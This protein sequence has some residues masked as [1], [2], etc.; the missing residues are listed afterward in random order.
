MSSK[1]RR[2][3]TTERLSGPTTR[4]QTKKEEKAQ[5]EAVEEQQEQSILDL[6]PE[7]TFQTP[8]SVPRSV[9][10]E[11]FASTT[12]Q[13]K[14]EVAAHSPLD[15][16]TTPSLTSQNNDDDADA[17]MATNT[18]IASAEVQ[19]AK[20][21]ADTSS[22]KTVMITD[23]DKQAAI[24]VD[25]WHIA[26]DA[27]LRAWVEQ[28]PAGVLSMINTLRAQ[29]DQGR[30]LAEDI[31]DTT[32]DDGKDREIRRLRV[33]V[34]NADG[35]SENLRNQ[36][37]GLETH[38]EELAEQ[39]RELRERQREASTSTFGDGTKKLSPKLKD[40]PVFT[41]EE[42]GDV[43]Y[44][45]WEMSIEDRL[46]V[47]ADHYPTDELKVIFMCNSVGGEA[48]EHI[49]PR[50]DRESSNPFKKP[51]EVYEH[52][53]SIYGEV[54]R[55]GTARREYRKTYQGVNGRFGAFKSK[56]LRLGGVLNYDESIIRDDM[57]D[58]M[59]PRLRD[60][61]RNNPHIRHRSSFKELCDWL[62]QLD[63]DQLANIEKT[64]SASTRRNPVKGTTGNAPATKETTSKTTYNSKSYNRNPTDAARIEL[65]KRLGICHYCH[66]PGHIARYCPNKDQKDS[67]AVNEL[68]D[69][70]TT[71][72]SKN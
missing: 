22:R 60:A 37:E 29:R 40:P 48:L 20:L 31:H 55:E 23:E 45:D 28:N 1:E 58:Q 3:T 70:D 68:A 49:R 19:R 65:E 67:A 24:A 34:A 11:K 21:L 33:A 62:Q 72:E 18:G 66:E 27:H 2:T 44:E 61:L 39:I 53:K 42:G 50:R 35:I 52:L 47:N 5:A 25:E 43:K 6:L 71:E 46:H 7:S 30:V 41:G 51:A 69:V 63:N 17:I 15:S 36:N 4:S 9:N 56:L 57:C 54:D 14:F 13:P 10:T 38:V 26:T 59:A 16:P 12:K 8:S 64:K 32:S